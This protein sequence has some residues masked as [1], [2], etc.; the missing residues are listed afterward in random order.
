M[1]IDVQSLKKMQSDANICIVAKVVDVLPPSEF[2][3]N[4]KLK[5][6]VSIV[7][8]GTE[9]VQVGQAIDLKVDCINS[10]D[11]EV[12]LSTPSYSLENLRSAQKIR[13]SLNQNQTDSQK[14][15]LVGGEIQFLSS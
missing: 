4:A 8:K 15:E 2:P 10:E 5:I 11:D 6:E 3:G 7:E 12:L 1:A 14:F 13:V 9:Y